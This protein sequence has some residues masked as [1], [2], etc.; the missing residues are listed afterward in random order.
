MFN[1]IYNVTT[2]KVISYGSCQLSTENSDEQVVTLSTFPAI[3]Q[4]RENQGKQF[5]F[6]SDSNTIEVSE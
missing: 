6:N 3:L 1:L 5:L 4:Q 2:K